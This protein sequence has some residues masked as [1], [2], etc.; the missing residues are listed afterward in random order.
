MKRLAFICLAFCCSLL[1]QATT[2][3]TAAFEVASV[4]PSA[5]AS[6]RALIQAVPG[7]LLMENFAPRTLIV[8][9]YGVGDYQVAGGPSW[10]GSDRF[11][12]Q[13][14]AEGNA[15][16]QQMEGPMLQSLLVERFK[17]AFHRET[18]QLPVYELTRSNTNAKLQ[19]TK[20]GSCTTYSLAAPA[21]PPPAPGAPGTVFCGFPHLTQAGTNRAIDGTGVSM[22]TLAGN[23]AR[24]VRRAV[25]DK[26]GLTGAYDL[27]LEWT[28]APMNIP[29]PD[30]SDR[31]SIFTAVT[32]QLGLKLESAKVPVEV[33]VIDHVERPSAN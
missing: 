23:I 30:V 6:D 27:H 2:P 8:L 24:T 22:A 4:K 13:A 21:P 20:D 10:I 28:E 1:G 32:E 26:T 31:P 19:L 17:L 33:I 15:T 29:N 9:A 14:K 7:R 5:S 16:V 12:V 3:G 18:Q 25:I 11:D